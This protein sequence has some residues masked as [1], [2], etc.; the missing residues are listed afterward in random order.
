MLTY[1]DYLAAADLPKF[2]AK[3][4]AQHKQSETYRMAVVADAY[5]RQR[6]TT[7][8]EFTDM[9]RRAA[10]N[11]VAAAQMSLAIASNYF[12]RFNTQRCSYLLGNGVAFT[13]TEQ[14]RNEA[15]ILVNVDVIK[16]RLGQDYDGQLYQWA[17][18]ALIHGV[19]YG[20]WDSE[21]LYVFPVTQ[22]AP[23]PDEDTGALMAGVR[24]WRIDG[25]HPL[26]AELY[27]AEGIFDFEGV[28]RGSETLRA[29]SEAPRAYIE[30][31]RTS[32]ARGTVAVG[33]VDL[34]AFPVIPMYGSNLR[35][36]TLVGLREKIDAWDLIAS[37]LAK[38]LKDVA[39]IYWIMSNAN[40]MS[41]AELNRMLEDMLTNHIINVDG[42]GFDG[43][44][45]EAMAPYS[46]EVPHQGRLSFLEALEKSMY[47]DFGAMDVRDLT[48]GATN[49]HI[50]AAYQALDEE[51]DQL[52][53]QVIEAV[54]QQLKLMGID[55]TP[56]FSRSKAKNITE[57]TNAV[58]AS[59]QYLD[60][61]AVLDHLP[62]I[63]V[64]EKDAILQRMDAEDAR[65]LRVN[66]TGTSAGEITDEV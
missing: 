55:D 39:A 26:K 1:Q 49:D 17:Y 30:R 48:A 41:Q 6:N 58:M 4:I 11:G 9:L 42:S 35:Q 19:A 22:F 12:R 43:S 21:R 27:T 3:V 44:V 32:A 37:G 57:L 29:A 24:F 2:V 38:D 46:T 36:S 47:R 10:A 20:Y 45:R 8:R 53:L 56:R 51:A 54:R 7:I 66:G 63:T 64:D 59:A 13:R 28:S 50:D 34:P 65:R 23:L 40:A 15:G 61:E 33:R 62:F 14:R 25:E 31:T 16:E 18:H 60:A 5:D 52:E